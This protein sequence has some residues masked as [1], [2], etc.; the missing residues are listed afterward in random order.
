[1]TTLIFPL[2]EEQGEHLLVDEVGGEMPPTQLSQPR[3][4][5]DV[6]GQSLSACL[7]HTESA[8]RAMRHGDVLEVVTSDPACE[9]GLPAW[10]HAHGHEMVE[11]G[12]DG[13]V[14][15][16]LLRVG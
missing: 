8:I 6:R 16:F 14:Y 10:A 15:R 2:A 9:D 7:E 1:M 13:H 12:G 3:R 5:L 11:S 4:R